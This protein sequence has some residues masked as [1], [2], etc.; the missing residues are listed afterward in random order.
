[1]LNGNN[2]LKKMIQNQTGKIENQTQ[3]INKIFNDYSRES[4]E[5]LSEQINFNAIIEFKQYLESIKNRISTSSQL[6]TTLKNN[7]EYEPLQPL[8]SQISTI[9]D[10]FIKGI[11]NLIDINK[12]YVFGWMREK[13]KRIDDLQKYAKRIGDRQRIAIE[14][15]QYRNGLYAGKNLLRTPGQQ[16]YKYPQYRLPNGGSKHENLFIKHFK[17]TLHKL[18]KILENTKLSVSDREEKLQKVMKNFKKDLDNQIIKLMK[19]TK[20]TKKKTNK[21]VKRS[22]NKLKKIS[23]SKSKTKKINRKKTVKKV[24]KN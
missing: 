12:M 23:K 18:D 4:L 22:I 16:Y 6:Q 8:F 19:I 2:N 14:S 11:D 7:P 10:K 9:L 17:K 3:K 24:K 13:D 5:K 20:K 1:M 15:G 21:I